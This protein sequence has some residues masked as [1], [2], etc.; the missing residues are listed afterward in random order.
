MTDFWPHVVSKDPMISDE[1]VW[2]LINW[3]SSWRAGPLVL[4]LDPG[5]SLTPRDEI[6]SQKPWPVSERLE[7]PTGRESSKPKTQK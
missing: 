7:K 6:S 1:E 4:F 5:L 2:E 3:I